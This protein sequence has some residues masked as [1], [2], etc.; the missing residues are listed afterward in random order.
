MAVLAGEGQRHIMRPNVAGVA[1]RELGTQIPLNMAVQAHGHRANDLTRNRVKAVTHLS[2]TI[3]AQ[4]PTG[5]SLPDSI[6]D[7]AMRGTQMIVRDHLRKIAVTDQTIFGMAL[8]EILDQPLMCHFPIRLVPSTL[9]ACDAAQ[10]TVGRLQRRRLD[11]V[12]V[13]LF[14]RRGT[15]SQGLTIKVAI[16]ALA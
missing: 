1:A 12:A 2:V 5:R 14:H 11:Q 7:L 10:R 13:Q 16:L 6:N 4:H 9:V 8:T 3:A 15:G